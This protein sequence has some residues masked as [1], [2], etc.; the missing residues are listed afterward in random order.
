MTSSSALL[1][2]ESSNDAKTKDETDLQERSTKKSKVESIVILITGVE[3]E[4]QRDEEG[5][6]EI[7]IGVEENE[8][9]GYE[10]PEFVFSRMEENS[11]TLEVRC[12][13]ET[14]GIENGL[15]GFGN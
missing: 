15:Q 3:D 7:G 12:D 6:M 1:G 9:G 11:S 8:I 14:I 4:A 10:C 13:C 2:Q 5:E